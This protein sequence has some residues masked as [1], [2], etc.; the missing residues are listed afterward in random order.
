MCNVLKY[1]ERNLEA[2]RT[3][4]VRI[5][6]TTTYITVNSK[7]SVSSVGFRVIVG[8]ELELELGVQVTEQRVWH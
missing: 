2:L 6:R 8:I 4:T 3:T 1:Y 7:S 5:K